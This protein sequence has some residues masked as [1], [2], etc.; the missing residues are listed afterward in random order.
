[1]GHIAPANRLEPARN[2]KTEEGYNIMQAKPRQK[3]TMGN[4]THTQHIL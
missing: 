2:H 4:S 1:M 3:D